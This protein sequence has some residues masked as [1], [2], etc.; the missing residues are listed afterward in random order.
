MRFEL[1][2]LCNVGRNERTMN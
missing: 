2:T 1:Q